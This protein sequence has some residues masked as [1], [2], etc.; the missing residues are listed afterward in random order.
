MTLKEFLKLTTGNKVRAKNHRNA[1]Q[2]DWG[3]N[4]CVNVL[5]NTTSTKSTNYESQL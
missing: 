3:A 5:G 2:M 4:Y 1:E